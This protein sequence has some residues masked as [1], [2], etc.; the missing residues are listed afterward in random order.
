MDISDHIIILTLN[1]ADRAM[2]FFSRTLSASEHM[3]IENVP[4]ATVETLHEWSHYLTRH[5]LSHLTDQILV[6]FIFM[7]KFGDERLRLLA[8]MFLKL[9]PSFSGITLQMLY[10][11]Y[12]VLLLVMIC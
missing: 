3:A 12:T 2:A 1:Q 4:Y 7:W 11:G 5:N 8:L 9:M 10:L 6:V